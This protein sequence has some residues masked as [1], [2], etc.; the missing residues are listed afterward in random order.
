MPC[1]QPSSRGPA[2]Q[3]QQRLGD[4]LDEA[5]D[6]VRGAAADHHRDEQHQHRDQG[7][8]AE[9]RGVPQRRADVPALQQQRRQPDHRQQHLAG[10]GEHAAEHDRDADRRRENP[11]DRQ[12]A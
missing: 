6:G 11:Q 5:A 12:I 7:Q 3:P 10:G 2:D 1:S 4:A 9:Q 8:H